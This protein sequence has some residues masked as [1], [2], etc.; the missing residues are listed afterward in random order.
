MGRNHLK[1]GNV[2]VVCP[3]VL[4]LNQDKARAN[5]E[6]MTVQSIVQFC[7]TGCKHGVYR[8][9]TLQEYRQGCCK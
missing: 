8:K 2:N 6:K 7:W 1:T 3:A 5:V 9:R 4:F